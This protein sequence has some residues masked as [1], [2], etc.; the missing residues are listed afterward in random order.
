VE[1]VWDEPLEGVRIPI[2]FFAN[3][4]VVA[5][6]PDEALEYVRPFEPPSARASLI[7]S[8]AEIEEP[9]RA[10]LKGVVRT[11]G[12]YIFCQEGE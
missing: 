3:Y 11:H 2:G 8:E 6:T 4:W 9:C 1:G 5:D 12:G 10:S 7:V